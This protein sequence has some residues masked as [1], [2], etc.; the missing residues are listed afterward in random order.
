MAYDPNPNRGP[1][2][3]KTYPSEVAADRP[4]LVTRIHCVEEADVMSPDETLRGDGEDRVARL[5]RQLRE[6]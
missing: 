2:R 5:N 3:D 6:G 1:I 4:A